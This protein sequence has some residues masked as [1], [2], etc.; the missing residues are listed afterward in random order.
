VAKVR[1][2]GPDPSR[3]SRNW[4]DTFEADAA[5]FQNDLR[6]VA[7]F[8]SVKKGVSDLLLSCWLRVLLR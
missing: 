5:A 1:G 7:G 2:D 4:D 8:K 3:P 6:K